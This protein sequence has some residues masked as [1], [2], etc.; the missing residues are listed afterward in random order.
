M[1]KKEQFLAV[2]KELRKE[3][4]RK[5]NQTVDLVINLKEFDIKRD[6]FNIAVI[7]PHEAKRKKICAFLEKPSIVFDYVIAKA[8]F[9]RLSTKELKKIVKDYDFCIAL[10]KL[11]PDIAKRFGRLLGPAGKMPDPKM[12][13]V[14]LRE[15]D[16]MMSKLAERLRRTIKIKT[17]EKSIKIAIGKENMS[18]EQ[19]SENA[20]VV[21]DA[22]LAALPK[23]K[24]NIKNVMLKL[25]MSKPIKVGA[26]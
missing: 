22:V 7:L 13:C 2:L 18:D 14:M 26:K 1:P 12:G 8:E 6:S 15:D 19:I 25:T 24:A 11:M 16:A 21:Y 20:T 10:A 5:F 4:K 9:E 23:K 17:K 3:K